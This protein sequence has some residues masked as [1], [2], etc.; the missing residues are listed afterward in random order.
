VQEKFLEV[1]LVGCIQCGLCDVCPEGVDIP[2]VLKIFN[3]YYASDKFMRDRAPSDDPARIKYA[4]IPDEKKA[5]MCSKCGICEDVCPQ[6]LPI[7]KLL[8]NIHW[9]MKK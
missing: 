4:D 1:G 8:K 7:I 6:Q 3:M 2:E 9:M 5:D